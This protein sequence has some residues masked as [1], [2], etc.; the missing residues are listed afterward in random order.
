MGS[1]LFSR[2]SS[3]NLC[4]FLR[5]SSVSFSHRLC[6]NTKCSALAQQCPAPTTTQRCLYCSTHQKTTPSPMKSLASATERTP[7]SLYSSQS[8]AQSSMFHEIGHINQEDLITVRRPS[9]RLV[10]RFE[11]AAFSNEPHVCNAIDAAL[12]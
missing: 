4:G 11:T 6:V 9:S 2:R 12:I 5:L 7:P 3:Y 8:R 1:Q 10:H